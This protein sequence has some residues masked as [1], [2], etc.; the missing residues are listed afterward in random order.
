MDSN[1]GQDQKST[2]L[3]VRQFVAL[4]RG[5]DAPHAPSNPWI[6][7]AVIP[8]QQYCLACYGTRWFDVVQAVTVDGR[9]LAVSICRCCGAEV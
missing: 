9:P 3:S 6:V 7:Q 5:E 4:A 8:A 2:S 1:V